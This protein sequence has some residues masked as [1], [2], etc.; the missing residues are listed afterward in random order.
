MGV[1]RCPFLDFCLAIG[2]KALYVAKNGWIQHTFFIRNVILRDV[3]V[4]FLSSLLPVG[5]V[6]FA[7]PSVFRLVVTLVSSVFS[8]AAASYML[9]LTREERSIVVSAKNKFFDKFFR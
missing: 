9:G 3:A 7:E 1:L 6:A 5:V 8:V 2:S 4:L